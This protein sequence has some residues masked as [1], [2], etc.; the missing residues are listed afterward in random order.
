MN[1]KIGISKDNG[2]SNINPNS[3]SFTHAKIMPPIR[4]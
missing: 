4:C 1:A 2:I 3:F